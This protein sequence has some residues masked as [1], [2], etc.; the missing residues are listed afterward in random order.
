MRQRNSS[1]IWW[2]FFGLL[3]AAALIL[4]PGFLSQLRARR[5]YAPENVVLEVTDITRDGQNAQVKTVIRNEGTLTFNRLEGDLDIYKG[6]RLLWSVIC[7]YEGEVAAGK[8]K[9]VAFTEDDPSKAELLLSYPANQLSYTWAPSS[10]RFVNGGLMV[11]HFFEKEQHLHWLIIVWPAVTVCSLAAG[12]LALITRKRKEEAVPAESPAAENAPSFGTSEAGSAY[13][14]SG[15]SAYDS[16]SS[17]STFG[18]GF[19]DASAYDTSP[20][21]SAGTAQEYTSAKPAQEFSTAEPVQASSSS[22]D[23]DALNSAQRR[24]EQASW[25]GANSRSQ[26][27]TQNAELQDHFKRTAYSE[28]L[29]ESANLSG[30]DRDAFD[31]AK[32]SFEQASRFEASYRASGDSQKQNA[33]HAQYR[34]ESAYAGMLEAVAE[35]DGRRSDA[36]ES[37][38]KTYERESFLASNY[39]ASGSK[40]N[41][42]EAEHRQRLAY[43]NMLKNTSDLD[44]RSADNYA[45][46]QRSY[47]SASRSAAS[48]RRQGMTK[49]AERAEHHMRLAE[50]NML[51]V[52]AEAKGNGREFEDARRDFENASR[53]Y[54]EYKN[55]G[56]ERDANREKDYMDRAYAKMMSKV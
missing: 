42:A 17:G 48:Y 16:G 7:S 29:R 13:A 49:D 50:A 32:K 33:E 46:A 9:K 37:A 38:K 31:S 6:E 44:R 30:S 15:G 20:T 40:E 23:R 52:K 1:G 54:M 10:A 35:K 12:I 4:L 36:F 14:F 53:H 18:Y 8:E 3:L 21:V 24:L 55:Q 47:E 22:V 56:L 25:T 2:L 5:N 28:V 27:L 51:K 39:R 43:A 34:R 26:G 41:A 19:S 45:S 11:T